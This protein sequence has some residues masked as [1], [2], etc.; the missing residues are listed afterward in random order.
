MQRGKPAIDP[1]A[2]TASELERALADTWSIQAEHP[3]SSQGT[4]DSIELNYSL[5]PIEASVPIPGQ[6]SDSTSDEESGLPHGKKNDS[7]RRRDRVLTLTRAFLSRAKHTSDQNMKRDESI[8]PYSSDGR[9]ASESQAMIESRF[10]A[11]R[12]RVN[13]MRNLSGNT[14]EAHGEIFRKNQ[15][16]A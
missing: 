8:D 2:Q 10:A 16:S 11:V 13:E 14:R 4:V 12:Q 3:M 1:Q 9:L 6:Q 5:S 7:P 15:S